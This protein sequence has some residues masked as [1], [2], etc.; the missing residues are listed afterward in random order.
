MNSPETNPFL[1]D[2]PQGYGW[3]LIEGSGDS[4]PTHRGLMAR[5]LEAET[6]V[7]Y[8]DLLTSWPAPGH[9]LALAKTMINKQYLYPLIETETAEGAAYWRLNPMVLNQ[10]RTE[11]LGKTL[12][13]A[14]A[15]TIALTRRRLIDQRR[16]VPHPVL[17]NFERLLQLFR[18]RLTKMPPSQA[19]ILLL[20]ALSET[21][22]YR[23]HD[24]SS[25]LSMNRH[26]ARK[27]H[28]KLTPEKVPLQFGIYKTS[29]F[30]MPH[31]QSSP[32]DHWYLPS[33]TLIDALGG[34]SL[35][36]DLKERVTGITSTDF[37]LSIHTKS[38][39]TLTK[40]GD[41][42]MGKLKTETATPP[43]STA[44]SVYGLQ[45]GRTYQVTRA[46]E[47]LATRSQSCRYQAF[48]GEPVQLLTP[49]SD[50]TPYLE[51]IA[52]ILNLPGDTAFVKNF[53]STPDGCGRLI[54]F[55]NDHLGMK[56]P[57]KEV[58]VGYSNGQQR[59]GITLIDGSVLVPLET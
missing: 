58:L 49:E 1:E 5:L 46:S 18:R 57:S 56:N 28:D 51:T 42:I 10:R 14:I 8:S 48:H 55:L 40:M 32:A 6:W 36:D 33:P 26:G 17:G 41:D 29:D 35:I 20:V 27:L 39:A 13:P 30:L 38:A 7:P 45:V 43:P 24:Q 37:P 53:L 11:V 3:A 23:P 9:P 31:P 50:F 47:S 44:M 2:A 52:R 22:G 21:E 34:R 59:A 54:G 16:P 12:D 19:N 15:K 4:S 25:Q